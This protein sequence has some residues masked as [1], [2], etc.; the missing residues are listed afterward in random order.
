MG[1]EPGPTPINN[2]EV[3]YGQDKKILQEDRVG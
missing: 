3:S 1:V 2:N